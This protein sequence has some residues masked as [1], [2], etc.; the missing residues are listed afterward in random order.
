MRPTDKLVDPLGDSGSRECSDVIAN[1]ISRAW[2]EKFAP[3]SNPLFHTRTS[4]S[5]MADNAAGAQLV[6]QNL[7]MDKEHC[8]A[9]VLVI[10]ATRTLVKPQYEPKKKVRILPAPAELEAMEV[11]RLWAMFFYHSEYILRLPESFPHIHQ[12]L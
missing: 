9:H 1:T 8:T 10:P 7:G 3:G 12:R 5:G 11:A 2:K 6:S 4:A